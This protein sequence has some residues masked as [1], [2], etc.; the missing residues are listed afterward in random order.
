MRKMVKS[1][2]LFILYLSISTNINAQENLKF[3]VFGGAGFSYN[4]VNYDFGINGID[5]SYN[6]NNRFSFDIGMSARYDISKYIG[7]RSEAQFI[8]KGGS[9]VS[10]RLYSEGLTAVERE[11]IIYLDY[12]QISLLPQ[13]NLHTGLN[14]M[15]YLTTGGYVSFN[16][17][18]NET[19]YANTYT[20]SLSY[21]KN[22]SNYINSTDAGIVVGGGFE[23]VNASN[24]GITMD[25]RFC[26]GLVNFY[27]N[28]STDDKIIMKNYSLSINLGYVFF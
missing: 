24:Q 28:N 17:G 23:S 2:I 10:N 22:I 9:V 16:T 12:I 6:S 19:V 7:I 3:S 11:H 15:F 18:S 14:S 8:R 13:L 1:L 20:Q 26:I 21:N 5:T 25:L 27:K 4:N